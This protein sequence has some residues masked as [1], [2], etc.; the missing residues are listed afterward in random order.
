AHHPTEQ[1]RVL[2]RHRGV[3]GWEGVCLGHGPGAPSYPRPL[4]VSRSRN[5]VAKG[6]ERTPGRSSRRGAVPLIVSTQVG[7]TV[8]SRSGMSGTH[9]PS[10]VISLRFPVLSPPGSSPP[11]KR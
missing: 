5:T 2:L 1:P 8:S 3:H 11:I 6:K 9:I 4:T 7:R 10:Y